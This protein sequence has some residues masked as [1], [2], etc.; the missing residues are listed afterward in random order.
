MSLCCGSPSQLTYA[1]NRVEVSSTVVIQSLTCTQHITYLWAPLVSGMGL[2]PRDTVGTAG[3]IHCASYMPK[4]I[5]V[6]KEGL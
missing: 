5:V 6:L 2:S 1:L 3:V 4:P